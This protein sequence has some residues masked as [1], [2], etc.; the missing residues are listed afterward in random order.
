MEMVLIGGLWLDGS[1]WDDVVPELERR[2]RRAHAVTLPGQGDGRSDATL[3]D[4]VDA[5]VA[6][7]DDAA[8]RSGEQVLVVGHSGACTLAWIAADRR[9]E[10]VAAVALVGGMPG[11]DGASY[12]D[13]FE[14]TGDV[15]PFPGW[16]PFAGP[17]TADLSA[18]LKERIAA[19]M[20]PVPVAVTRGVV[21]L[22]D[23]R[24]YDVRVVMV[25]PEYTPDDARGWVEGGDIPEL[26]RAAQVDYVGI[27]SGHWPMHSA[28]VSLA[29]LLADL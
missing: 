25:C 8:K 20:H 9:P 19:S 5:V 16:E 24:R 26:E 28:P 15:V 13:F 14:P 11:A 23:P 27:D 3:D 29:A 7:V 2:G 21:R 22:H 18:D 1:C 4:Q 6:A 12:A 10:Q 17:D